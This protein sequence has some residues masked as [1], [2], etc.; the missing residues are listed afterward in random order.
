MMN[1]PEFPGT[2]RLVIDKRPP[3]PTH[4]AIYGIKGHPELLAR[5][6]GR[7]IHIN[8]KSVWFTEL[9]NVFAEELIKLEGQYHITN[10]GFSQAEVFYREESSSPAKFNISSKVYGHSLA[11]GLDQIPQNVARQTYASIIRYHQAEDERLVD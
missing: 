8:G 4:P 6:T 2:N 1:S 3:Y 5:K 11:T 9:D 10:P 7:N